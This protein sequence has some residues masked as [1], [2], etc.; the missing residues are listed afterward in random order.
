MQWWAWLV[1]WAVLVL[2]LVAMLVLL[3]VRLFRKAVRVLDALG[4]L[5]EKVALIQDRVEDLADTPR[6]S[7]ILLARKPQSPIGRGSK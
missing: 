5:G 2:A 3:A 7:A 1:I 6:S 4:D